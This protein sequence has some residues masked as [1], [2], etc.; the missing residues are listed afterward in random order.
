MPGSPPPFVV[1]LPACK[2]E[3]RFNQPLL[4]QE[5]NMDSPNAGHSA[6]V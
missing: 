6:L 4:R 2:H 5:M 1:L 3:L